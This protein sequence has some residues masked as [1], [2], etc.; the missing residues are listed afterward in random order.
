MNKLIVFIFC[1]AFSWAYYAQSYPPIPK[2]I[3]YVWLGK[4]PLP[5]EVQQT[6]A[7]WEKYA[8]DFKIMRWDETNCDLN[9]NEFIR[10]AYDEKLWAW[11]SDYCRL[12]AL[13]ETGGVYMDT[14]QVLH[15]PIDEIIANTSVVMTYQSKH[16]MS[17]SFIAVTPKHPFIKDMMNFYNIMQ[18]NILPMPEHLN[19]GLERYFHI[20]P[21]GEFYKSRKLTIYPTPVLMIDF[22]GGENIA[23]HRY[24]AA[25]TELAGVFNPV[26]RQQFLDEMAIPVCMKDTRDYIIPY[27]EKNGYF[28]SNK[29]KVKIILKTDTVL[30]FEQ[31]KKRHTLEW[32]KRCYKT[33]E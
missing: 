17:A 2:I 16:D 21:N 1:F 15:A 25:G 24:D 13:Y 20:S 31:N 6:I 22:G 29:Q 5:A 26:Y 32:F 14:D 9:A 3:H 18:F 11:A 8:P 7:S 30:I 19:T 28:Y 12:Q 33:D 4:N 10:R 27:D 23:T